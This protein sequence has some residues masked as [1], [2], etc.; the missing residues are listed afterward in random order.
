MHTLFH[1]ILTATPEVHYYSFI[2]NLCHELTLVAGTVLGWRKTVPGPMELTME[3]GRP[4]LRGKQGAYQAVWAPPELLLTRMHL[5]L[6]SRSG[7]RPQRVSMRKMNNVLK[8]C[9]DLAIPLLGTHPTEPTAQLYHR[10]TQR[11][12]MLLCLKE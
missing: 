9:Y 3:E 7:L 5:A 1:F 12:L 2:L 11:G 6:F 8:I 10:S 4:M